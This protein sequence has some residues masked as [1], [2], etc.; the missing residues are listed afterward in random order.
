MALKGVVGQHRIVM[1]II[2]TSEDGSYTLEDVGATVP[3]NL[4]QAQVAAGF[5]TGEI[6]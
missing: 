5:I 1:G 6:V 3:L 4:S 2:S